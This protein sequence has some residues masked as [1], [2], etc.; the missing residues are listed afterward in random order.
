MAA[1]FLYCRCCRLPACRIPISPFSSL[2]DTQM[3]LF[4]ST[5]ME[6]KTVV[7]KIMFSFHICFFYPLSFNSHFFILGNYMKPYLGNSHIV[8]CWDLPAVVWLELE[9]P[10]AQ[11]AWE[12][13]GGIFV[14]CTWQVSGMFFFIFIFFNHWNSNSIEQLGRTGNYFCA[15]LSSSCRLPALSN[16]CVQRWKLLM[17]KLART[18]RATMSTFLSPTA[19]PFVPSKIY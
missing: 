13:P 10:W 18:D 14:I 5:E 6:N 1:A 8:S 2:Y 12:D 4:S 3:K 19:L 15:H 16:K 17:H 11:L 9:V 7:D